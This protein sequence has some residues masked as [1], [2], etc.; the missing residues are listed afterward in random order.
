MNRRGKKECPIEES[1]VLYI[2]GE[3]GEPEE[4][5][6]LD[7]TARCPACRLRLNTLSSI[8]TELIARE[9]DIPEVALSPRDGKELRE[10]ARS[11]MRARPRKS[12]IF[13]P[14]II[15]AGGILAAGILLAVLGYRLS[16][17]I[18]NPRPILRGEKQIEIR[19]R[20][21]EGKIKEAPKVFSWSKVADSDVYRLEIVDDDLNLVFNASLA[22]TRLHLPEEVRQKLQRQKP[23]LWTVSASDD[24]ARELASA[25]GYFEIE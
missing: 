12:G 13:S 10:L 6:F 9:K 2:S 14:R 23:Y 11:Q 4:T 21:P 19:L 25:S 3:L 8:R 24:D 15:R 1:F 17:K 7:H 5:R 20:Q 18:S 22:G 16:V